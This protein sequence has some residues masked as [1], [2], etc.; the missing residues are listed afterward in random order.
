MFS[1]YRYPFGSSMPGRNF[2]QNSYRYGYNKGSEKDDE[3][4]GNGSFYDTYYRPYDARLGKWLSND[5]ITLP[6]ESPYVAMANNPIA[7]N[8][9]LGDKIKPENEEVAKDIK[10][11]RKTDK[12]FDK[13]YKSWKKQYRGKNDLV[14]HSDATK[15]NNSLDVANINTV[16]DKH[17]VLGDQLYYDGSLSKKPTT[18]A[19]EDVKSKQFNGTKGYF[20]DSKI[21][22][23]DMPSNV[24]SHWENI[25]A[26][27]R[28]EPILDYGTVR[29]NQTVISY[30]KST[31]TTVTLSG[32]HDLSTYTANPNG[33]TTTDGYFHKGPSGDIA[34]T[35]LV[36]AMS[37]KYIETETKFRVGK[38][39]VLKY[40]RTFNLA[41]DQN[42]R[43]FR[44]LTWKN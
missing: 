36:R 34:M 32:N 37:L 31:I 26:Y 43:N 2:N 10:H 23:T 38:S 12:E 33:E 1:V 8:D 9:P 6:F 44:T 13:K 18:V 39:E 5:P 40:T 14:I 3:I 35:V 25:T 21:F 16:T 11:L 28:G 22:S 41:P 24:F 30:P 15:T 29:L 19:Y 27:V 17:N 7:F 20:S 42:V 4:N